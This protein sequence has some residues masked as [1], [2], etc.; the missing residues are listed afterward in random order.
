MS[1]DMSR[2]WQSLT[3]SSLMYG[4]TSA[5]LFAGIFSLLNISGHIGRDMVFGGLSGGLSGLLISLTVG[6]VDQELTRKEII[7]RVVTWTVSN[8]IVGFLAGILITTSIFFIM[9]HLT[10]TVSTIQ[11]RSIF[12]LPLC[13]SAGIPLGTIIGL[14]IGASW[15]SK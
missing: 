10:G 14:L 4:L 8:S 15:H 9:S 1:K 6:M 5:L 7:T 11:L 3:T 13:C 12:D 2:N